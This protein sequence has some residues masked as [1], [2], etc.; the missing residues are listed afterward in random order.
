ML[1]FDQG[2]TSRVR[3]EQLSLVLGARVRDLSFQE[4]PGDVFA[5]VRERLQRPHGRLRHGGADY[6]AYALLDAVIDNYFLV[7]EA[8]GETIED[9]EEQLLTRQSTPIR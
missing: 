7:A 1:R 2:E 5:P 8:F 9:L 3:S 6:L 4:R